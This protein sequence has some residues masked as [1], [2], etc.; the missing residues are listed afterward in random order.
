ME[1]FFIH[2]WVSTIEPLGSSLTKNFAILCSLWNVSR[3]Y[4]KCIDSCAV[5]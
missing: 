3:Q 4:I 2:D 5:L 1:M